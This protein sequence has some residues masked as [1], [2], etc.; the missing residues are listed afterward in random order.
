M[1]NTYVLDTNALIDLFE[2][3]YPPDV[4][5][6]VKLR[7]ETLG[8]EG[9]IL[10]PLDV[11]QELPK[12]SASRDWLNDWQSLVV[13]LD[14]EIQ[15]ALIETMTV[16]PRI[17]DPMSPFPKDAADPVV[18]AVAK[19]RRACVVSNERRSGGASRPRIPNA[20]ELMSV[21]CLPVL[22]FLRQELR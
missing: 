5:P 14:E 15:V 20:C 19:A 17:I 13:E 12:G 21:P 4:F 18:V 22:D 10:V 1:K 7:V 2:R 8:H 11:Q 9:R 6:S 3:R 16:C